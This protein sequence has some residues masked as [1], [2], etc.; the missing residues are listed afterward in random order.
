[1]LSLPGSFY[2][3]DNHTLINLLA[4]VRS[5]L[6]WLNCFIR[7]VLV[8]PPHSQTNAAILGNLIGSK[9]F[10]LSCF[11]ELLLV[12]LPP[13]VTCTMYIFM[14]TCPTT[15]PFYH[16]Y[17]YLVFTNLTST[18]LAWRCPYQTSVLLL[19]ICQSLLQF[20]CLQ[21]PHSSSYHNSSLALLVHLY[22]CPSLSRT[23]P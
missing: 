22:L 20:P 18:V 15:Q 23:Q 7:A 14:P 19:L 11:S 6:L 12:D 17:Y 4:H 2:L 16:H 9:L 5:N 3:Q 8:W 10:W 21:K 1:M 13:S